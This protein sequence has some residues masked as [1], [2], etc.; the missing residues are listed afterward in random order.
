L[1]AQDRFVPD[2]AK[3]DPGKVAGSDVPA[4]FERRVVVPPEHFVRILKKDVA[5]V[6]TTKGP[7]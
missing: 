7:D 1:T 2:S 3:K 6:P 5:K 4:E